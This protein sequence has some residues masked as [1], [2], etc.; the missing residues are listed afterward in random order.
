MVQEHRSIWISDTH[1]GAKDTNSRYLLDF[2]Q[3]NRSEHL[4]L[5]GDI[6]DLWKVGA[7]WHWPVINQEIVELVM[8]K[9]RDGTKVYYIPGNHDQLFRHYIGSEINGVMVV[10]DAV[11]T[12]AD[13]RKFL[14]L[15]G[16]EFDPVAT[17]SRWLS[18][19][20]SNTYQILLR[21]NRYY[22]NFRRSIGWGY[23]SLSAFLKHQ[24]KVVVNFIG[25][26]KS[27]IILEAE[28]R[29]VDGLICGHIHHASF[30]NI[31]G[32]LYSNTGDWVE[33]CTVLV[34]DNLGSLRILHWADQQEVLF[35]EPPLLPNLPAYA[36]CYNN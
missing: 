22:N 25:D 2:L 36:H 3:N 18:K 34:E 35:V 24:A 21:L 9:A 4:Y 26:F 13:G 14:V 32:Y 10:R 7:F 17:Y 12:T 31:G 28:R 5:V 8:D 23:W 1:L 6:I 19:L 20:G 15:H 30:E 33:S 27:E 11:H 16:D 29:E